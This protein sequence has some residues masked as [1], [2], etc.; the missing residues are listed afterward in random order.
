MAS[1]DKVKTLESMVK[2]VEENTK[3]NALIKIKST[4]NFNI[5]EAY[6]YAAKNGFLTAV[7]FFVETG[8]SIR[9]EN[10]SALLAAIENDKM[11]I[12]SYLNGLVCYVLIAQNFTQKL[13][14]MAF[15]TKN[16]KLM[17]HVIRSRYVPPEKYYDMLSTCVKLKDYEEI[18]KCLVDNKPIDSQRDFFAECV[19]KNNIQILKYA[20]SHGFDPKISGDMA[21]VFAISSGKVDFV[22]FLIGWGCNPMC[23]QYTYEFLTKEIS[24]DDNIFHRVYP[25]VMHTTN[26]II[27]QCVFSSMTKKDKHTYLKT[28]M[29]PEKVVHKYE[30]KLVLGNNIKKTFF[31]KRLLRPTSMG[32][33]L[34]YL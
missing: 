31:L 21:L 2:F 9:Y 24:Y 16:L 26:P 5:N 15:K 22:E 12:V 19:N 25:A 20:V 17:K 23:K 29:V 8:C 33:L 13:T 4:T 10:D 32:M 6:V 14:D 3:E 7:R 1:D 30:N 28:A 11:H 34:T 27:V 18:A